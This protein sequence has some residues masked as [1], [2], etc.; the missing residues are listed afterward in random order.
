M[1]PHESPSIPRSIEAEYWVVDEEGRLTTPGALVSATEGA[2]REFVRPLLEVKTSPC[3]S[4]AALRAELLDRLRDVLRAAEERGKRLVPLAT[5]ATREEIEEFESERTRIQNE[6]VGRDFRYVRHCAGTHVHIEQQPGCVADQV[7]A[8]VAADPAL[9]LV[10]SS[11]YFQGRRLTRGARSELYRR[12]AYE[13]VPHQGQLWRYIDERAEWTR[14][15]ERRYEEFVRAAMDAGIDRRTVEANFDP[16]SAVWTPIQPRDRFGTVEWRS[17][18]TALPSQVV[19]LADRLASLTA[20]VR[21]KAVRIEGERGGLTDEALLLP[22][23]PTVLKHVDDAIQEGLDSER[24]R[25][26]LDRLGFE[27]EAYDPL[28]PRIDR[29]E[30]LTPAAARDLR[31]DAAARLEQD[32][33]Q[34]SSIDAD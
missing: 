16:E 30:E 24:L 13:T 21:E 25:R 5:P 4:T 3:R 6:V 7:N 33:Y 34:T 12:R 9:A 26:Y 11:P 23:F 22:D 1:P 14:R 29:G 28:A 18:D 10:N 31:L 15:L 8:F 2:E 27:V 32:V 17:P 20:Q 19:R